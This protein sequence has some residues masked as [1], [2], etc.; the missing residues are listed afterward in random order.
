[1][2]IALSIDNTKCSSIAASPQILDYRNTYFEA[3]NSRLKKF[4]GKITILDIHICFVENL[5]LSVEIEK[6]QLYFDPRHRW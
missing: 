4:I 3:Q 2:S 5:Q 1:M 6:L